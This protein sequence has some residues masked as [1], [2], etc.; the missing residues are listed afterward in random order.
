MPTCN[1]K[2][3]C[4]YNDLILHDV[5]DWQQHLASA[6]P[7]SSASVCLSLKRRKTE[8]VIDADLTVNWIIHNADKSIMIPVL[9]TECGQTE[10]RFSLYV[11]ANTF[12]PPNNHDFASL[13]RCS[14][15]RNHAK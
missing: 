2:Q 11:L 3:N 4:R 5:T 10:R 9:N 14:F 7:S 13:R 8:P 6:F 1:K 12:I 15:T